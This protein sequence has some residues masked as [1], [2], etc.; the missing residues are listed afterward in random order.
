MTDPSEPPPWVIVTGI[1]V[2]LGVIFL[3]GVGYG[4]QWGD[5]FGDMAQWQYTPGWGNLFT[6]TVATA[7]IIASV[8]VSKI[9]LK[10]NATQ[11][12]QNRLDKRNIN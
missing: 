2:A 6:A 5:A 8:I 7:A 3:L 10:R 1:I 11:F 9:T 4:L 12:E